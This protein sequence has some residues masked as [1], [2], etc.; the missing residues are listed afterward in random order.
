MKK[1]IRGISSAMCKIWL[2]KNDTEGGV[3]L[4]AQKKGNEFA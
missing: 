3:F 4:K 1:R 2:E